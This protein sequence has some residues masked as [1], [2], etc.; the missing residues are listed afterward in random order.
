MRTEIPILG[1]NK[2][3]ASVGG[4]LEIGHNCALIGISLE[5]P[6]RRMVE[7]LRDG[8]D[9][10]QHRGQEAAGIA[11]VN[12]KA[13]R[14]RGGLGLRESA[15]PSENLTSSPV[16][17]VGIGH[18]RYSTAGKRETRKQNQQNIQPFTF[19]NDLFEFAIAHNG[20]V[21]WNR[22]FEQ[23]EPTSDTY[24]VGK[25][26]ASSD[27]PFVKSTIDVL[28]SLNGAYKFLF[29]TNDNRLFVASDPWGFRPGVIGRLN[30]NGSSGL[31]FASET[32]GLK[33]VD[34]E[35][36]SHF[37]RGVFAEITSDSVI[38]LWQDPRTQEVPE[39]ACSF[40][41][42]YFA[43]AASQPREGIT[44][45]SIRVELGKRLAQRAKP[46]GD[47]VT[48]VPDSGRSYA[49]G[50]SQELHLNLQQVIHS[51]RYKGRGFIKPQTPA[52][53]MKESFLK[54]RFI[55]EGIAGKELIV[56]DDSIVRG[57]TT[58]GLILALFNLGAKRIELLSGVPPLVAPCH[59]GIDFPTE[60]ELIFNKLTK[61]GDKSRFSEELA[62]WLVDQDE[63][64]AKRL[65]ISYQTVEDYV[66]LVEDIP[67]GTPIEHSGGCYH[68]VSGIVP[69]G[70]QT[71]TISPTS[72]W[73]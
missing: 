52:E 51:N 73:T 37:P 42:A 69:E 49:E 70:A 3:E 39:A 56:V 54:Y 33:A 36:V 19:T 46:K 21:R 65:R 66:S 5:K 53:R 34:A 71:K 1:V 30:K 44:N 67:V 61:D 16:V 27:K 58:Q 63:E 72:D 32:G 41:K 6:D 18:T 45:H 9:A 47:L 48:P 7:F 60:N 20:T 24:G 26:I 12:K 57:T 68:C 64:L 50:V 2:K 17:R 38:S 15:I 62:L 10:Q 28:S 59:W 55:P 35:F 43:D 13:V 11:W 4:E 8:I 31:V 40:E 22:P 25:T 23:D 29:I 14:H